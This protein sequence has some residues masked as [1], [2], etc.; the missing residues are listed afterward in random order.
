ME[1]KTL[2]GS[3]R[4]GVNIWICVCLILAIHTAL[5]PKKKV[6]QKLRCL[7]LSQT[8]RERRFLVSPSPLPLSLLSPCPSFSFFLGFFRGFRVFFSSHYWSFA[9]GRVMLPCINDLWIASPC[10]ESTKP[11][12]FGV[13]PSDSC[14][15]IWLKFLFSFLFIII[16]FHFP[17]LSLRGLTKE[18]FFC[19]EWLHSFM[20]LLHFSPLA[21]LSTV[22]V[23]LDWIIRSG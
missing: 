17:Q 13:K 6:E 23:P 10:L 15:Q 1:S 12:W 22:L 20:A 16:S 19:A 18:N 8:D 11:R 4:N 21:S 2:L 9:P 7:L 3:E 5:T 14:Y